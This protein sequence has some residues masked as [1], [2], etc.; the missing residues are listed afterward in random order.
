[1]TPTPAQSA[2]DELAERLTA[3]AVLAHDPAVPDIAADYWAKS[4]DHYRAVDAALAALVA[5]SPAAVTYAAV[6]RHPTRV[7][8]QLELRASLTTLLG[9]RGDRVPEVAR[10][11]GAADEQIWIDYHL[12]ADYTTESCAPPA[13]IGGP[14]PRR[15]QPRADDALVHVVIP[16]RDRESGLRTRNLLAC[17]RALADQSGGPAHRV[18]VVETD[19]EPRSREAVAGLVDDYVFARKDGLFNKAWA[20]NVGMVSAPRDIRYSCVLD[21]DILVDRHFVAR[22]TARL[23]DGGHGTH[24]PFRWSLSLDEPS[25]LRA[26]ATRVVAGAAEVPGSVLRGLLLREPPGGCV[27]LRTGLF[28]TIGGFDERFEGWG[29]EDDDVV[30]RLSAAA[31]LVRFDDALLHLNHPRPEM[32]REDGEPFNAH[33]EPMN[34]TGAHPYGDREK[35]SLDR[36]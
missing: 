18:T 23:R 36:A 26:L 2:I 1:M 20:V 6:L 17:L 33:L 34:R 13:L 8:A 32:T 3:H 28:H 24:L 12:G 25:T 10:T 9:Q 35:F 27:W 14:A 22:N 11:V 31:P 19:V 21:A 15:V 4:E 30:A 5:D 16:F 7:A 29:G